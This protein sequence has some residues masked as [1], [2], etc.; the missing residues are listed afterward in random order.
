MNGISFETAGGTKYFF[1]S[2]SC[3][4]VPEALAH[5]LPHSSG[6]PTPFHP[7]NAEDIATHIKRYGLAELIIEVTATCNQRCSYCVYSESYTFQRDHG[8]ENISDENIIRAVDLYLD[9]LE[10]AAAYNPR[11]T[12]IITFYGGEPLIN[13]KAVRLAVDPAESRCETRPLFLLT[14]NATLLS[15]PIIEHFI[16]PEFIPIF[17]IDGDSE[18]H[19]RNRRFVNNRPTHARVV[20]RVQK[21][22]E[23]SGK[24]AFVN[25]VVDPKTDLISMMEYFVR[26]PDF[27][28][29]SVSPA[30]Y[31]GTTYYSQFS[32]DDFERMRLQYEEL[33]ALFTSLMSSHELSDDD[34]LRC[35]F[36]Y[37]LV[38]RAALQPFLKTVFKEQVSASSPLPYTGSCVPGDKLFIDFQGDFY[39]CEKIT[40]N[41]KIGSLDKG[42]DYEAIANIVGAIH[43]NGFAR[44]CSSCS[45]RNMCS[46]C[47]QSFLPG[48]TVV[49]N[50]ADCASARQGFQSALSR[51]Y[52]LAEANPGWIEQFAANYQ[53]EI[54]ALAIRQA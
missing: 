18:S 31:F 47:L 26:N 51:G 40:R 41:V 33:S 29:Y 25:S 4:V 3:I 50:P 16:E 11:R 36:L 34:K 12:P 39:A 48:E 10:A 7:P 32:G 22:V 30:N 54:R 43:K 45:I 9:E 19:D 2:S 17:S 6:A 28:P 13:Y 23:A 35:R 21:Y 27:W 24:P 42:F 20:S 53:G 52:G 15:A 8:K 14:T 37:A 46:L 5:R 38:G 49:K 44:G 1:D